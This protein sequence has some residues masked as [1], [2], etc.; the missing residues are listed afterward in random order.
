M[1][2]LKTEPHVPVATDW[3]WEAMVWGS[4]KGSIFRIK[5]PPICAAARV[6]PALQRAIGIHYLPFQQAGSEGP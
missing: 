2:L 6:A 5:A 1:R 4:L 3:K